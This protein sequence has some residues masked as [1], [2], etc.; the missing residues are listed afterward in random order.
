[1]ASKLW[2][3]S[4]SLK[5]LSKIARLVAAHRNILSQ[6]DWNHLLFAL[7]SLCSVARSK[8]TKQ[9]AQNRMGG[10]SWLVKI[11]MPAQ[12]IENTPIIGGN[13]VHINHPSTVND[14]T[15]SAIRAYGVGYFG[16]CW[17]DPT[18]CSRGFRRNKSLESSMFEIE[19]LSYCTTGWY[20]HS[21]LNWSPCIPSLHLNH[22]SC[23]VGSLPVEGVSGPHP[24]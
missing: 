19:P 21:P 9:C 17:R 6:E 2:V 24:A 8:S 16:A 14:S 10:T 23:P 20:R 15:L 4:W 11:K 13:R 18:V 22:T 1:M 7:A 5:N 3:I 12:E